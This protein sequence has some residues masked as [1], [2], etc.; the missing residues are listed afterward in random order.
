[1]LSG[2]AEGNAHVIRNVGG[3]A[4][5]DTIRSLVISHKLLAT[6]EWLVVHHTDCSMLTFTNEI[7]S[8]L[9]DDNL[10]TASFDG[11]KWANPKH[12]GGNGGGHF[13]NRRTISDLPKSLVEGVKRIRTHPLVPGSIPIC[14]FIYDCATG[15]LNEVKEASAA[16]KPT[17]LNLALA[18]QP[19]SV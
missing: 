7:M 18:R 19:H 2:L 14:S 11:M 1:V 10:E 16:G 8:D 13:I 4:S 5:D 12:G 3:R 17:A 9:L 6:N 15:K